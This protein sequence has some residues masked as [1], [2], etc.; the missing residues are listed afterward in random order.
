MQAATCSACAGSPYIASYNPD[1]KIAAQR[2]IQ[3]AGGRILQDMAVVNSWVV[4]FDKQASK[5][6]SKD[7]TPRVMST[8]EVLALV[9]QNESITAIEVCRDQ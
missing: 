3:A 4:V 7:A 8:P 2:A 6:A 9:D 5:A 1:D